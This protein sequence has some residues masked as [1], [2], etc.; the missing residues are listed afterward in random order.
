MVTQ[1][2]DVTEFHRLMQDKYAERQERQARRDRW[3][4]ILI[5][6]SMGLIAFSLAFVLAYLWYMGKLR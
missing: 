2:M 6:C 1:T 5:L 4:R 3:L